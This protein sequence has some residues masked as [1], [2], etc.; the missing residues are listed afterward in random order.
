VVICLF[1]WSKN[2]LELKRIPLLPVGVTVYF[3]LSL[4]EEV[5]D[6]LETE[7]DSPIYFPSCA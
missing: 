2:Y 3:F 6:K 5:K 7:R 4:E 1:A